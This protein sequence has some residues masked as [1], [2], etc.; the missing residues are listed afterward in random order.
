[1][2]TDPIR[3]L[4]GDDVH[5]RLHNTI[6]RYKGIPVYCVQCT[7]DG[8]SLNLRP[9]RTT[10]FVY[11][12]IHSSDEDLDVSSPP[13]GYLNTETCCVYVQRMATRKQHQGF[14]AHVANCH[15]EGI[16]GASIASYFAGPAF[17]D[18]IENKYPSIE[19]AIEHLNNKVN[20][21]SIAFHRKFAFRSTFE[22]I[23]V[24]HICKKIGQL[25]SNN[26]TVLLNPR[27]HTPVI[28][29]QLQKL[30]LETQVL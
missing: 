16:L 13:L 6:V 3:Y 30:G 28:E 21:Q 9:L 19:E 23:D 12:N 11:T 18:L 20:I 27:F 5:R 8:M 25:D 1:M 29:T 26:F 17:A 10:T 7:Y 24:H 14:C 2:L 22:G 4:N 15:Y